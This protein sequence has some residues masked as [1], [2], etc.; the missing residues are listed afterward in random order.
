MLVGGMTLELRDNGVVS[1]N[2][3]SG[4][5]AREVMGDES[6]VLT[7]VGVWSWRLP[8]LTVAG[9]FSTRVKIAFRGILN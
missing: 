4:F 2:C 3:R 5:C 7:W 6:E 9:V 8:T 1:V